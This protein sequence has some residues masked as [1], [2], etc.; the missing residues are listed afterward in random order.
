MLDRMT[1]DAPWA[2][3]AR[4]SA[5]VICHGFESG[6]E[7]LLRVLDEA[8]TE[9]ID[10]MRAAQIAILV[11][12]PDSAVEHAGHGEREGVIG[13]MERRHIEAFARLTSS[14]GR[15]GDAE[16]EVTI[17]SATK[18]FWLRSLARITLPILD[19]AYADRSSV[20]EVLSRLQAVAE[21][22]L[23]S[24][25]VAPPLTIAQGDTDGSSD[26]D[27]D[28]TVVALLGIAEIRFRGA[29]GDVGAELLRV[30]D[31]PRTVPV[32]RVPVRTLANEL[33]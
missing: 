1:W 17:S 12:R 21:D 3:E 15:D 27:L 20:V 24:V 11:G 23:K 9:P 19:A 6:R 31:D 8:E 5:A 26:D 4:A 7:L 28:R 14:A 2:R 30:A 10:R 29:R 22:R 33:H 32:L 25:Q 16:L 18:P 13:P